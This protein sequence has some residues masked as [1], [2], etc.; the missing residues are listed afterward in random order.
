MRLTKA[1]LVAGLATALTWTSTTEGHSM[2]TAPQGRG[3]LEWWGTCASGA[4]CH[5]PCEA[6][7]A[8]APILNDPTYPIQTIRRGDVLRV[9]WLRFNHPGGFVRLTMVPFE[10]SDEWRAFNEAAFQKSTCYETNCGPDSLNDDYF[11]PMNGQGNGVCSTTFTVPQTLPDGRATLQWVWYG[12]GVYYGD[13]DA[14]FGEYYTCTDYVVQGGAPHLDTAAAVAAVG[15]AGGARIWQGG[16]ASNPGTD[17]CKYWSSN[18]IGDCSFGQDRPPNPRSEDLLSQ[19]L[20]PCARTGSFV[21]RP[22]EFSAPARH[23]GLRRRK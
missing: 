13:K 21:G 12:G 9:E 14:G 17:L 3:N 22:A 2:M 23:F 4:G 8:R 18:Q 7:R 19:S 15:G 1:T 20:E 6:P 11:G 5:G 16:D 10:D